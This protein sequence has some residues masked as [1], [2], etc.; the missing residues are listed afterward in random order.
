MQTQTV[1]VSLCA[2]VFSFCVATQHATS[3]L[4]GSTAVWDLHVTYH[5]MLVGGCC[6]CMCPCMFV[7]CDWSVMSELTQSDR[8]SLMCV[9]A[10]AQPAQHCCTG[11]ADTAAGCLLPRCCA[12]MR[13][14]AC[15]WLPAHS[16]G[17]GPVAAFCRCVVAC[18][19]AAAT[20]NRRRCIM[21]WLLAHPA[22]VLKLVN[23]SRGPTG[24]A[25]MVLKLGCMHRAPCLYRGGL[26][27]FVALAWR[28]HAWRVHAWRH[29]WPRLS[30]LQPSRP[31]FAAILGCGLGPFLSS[32]AMKSSFVQ[33]CMCVGVGRNLP[34]MCGTF[35][36]HSCNPYSCRP[37]LGC[38]GGHAAA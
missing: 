16:R 22:V 3:R 5:A 14:F 37:H 33:R 20:A 34:L 18:Q 13:L 25:C 36:G 31:C 9:G 2:R 26:S 17:L 27:L 10:A 4:P 12:G 6:A 1:R 15:S 35:G 38:L 24:T 28:V 7:C 21:A 19:R 8:E 30:C 11:V 23:C 32:F 29:E